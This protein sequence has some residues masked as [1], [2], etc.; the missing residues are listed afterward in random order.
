MDISTSF[1]TNEDGSIR[2][3]NSKK[4][5]FF[6][7]TSFTEIR[8]GSKIVRIKSTRTIASGVQDTFLADTK[9]QEQVLRENQVDAFRLFNGLS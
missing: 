9:L 8:A 2:T 4:L 5:P 7:V 3:E 6:R 1:E